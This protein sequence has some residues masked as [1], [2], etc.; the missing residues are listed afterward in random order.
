MCIRD[1]CWDNEV[2]FAY[3]REKW[4]DNKNNFVKIFPA[5]SAFSLIVTSVIIAFVAHGV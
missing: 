5:L 4:F 2:T 1:R 3:K